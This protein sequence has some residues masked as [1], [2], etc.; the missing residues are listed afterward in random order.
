MSE[1]RSLRG[2]NI[3]WQLVHA[4]DYGVPQNRPRVLIV[5]IKKTIQQP[6]TN[7][8]DKAV[9]SGFLPD[10]V[11]GYP[12]LEEV[13]S[14]LIDKKFEYGGETTKYPFS[15]KNH[16]QEQIRTK[17][18]GTILEK[19]DHLT[20][21]EYSKHGAQIQAKFQAMIDN[22]G[23]MPKKYKTKKFAQ[24]LLP[25]K[26][27]NKGPTITIT[28]LPDDFV[29]YS[30]ARTP[31]VRECARMQT[32]PD[33]YQFAGKRTTGGI[34]RA[35]NPRENIFDREVPKYTQIGNAVPV[36][37]AYEIGLHLNQVLK[38]K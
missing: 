37:L 28:S 32:F 20:E 11:G 25:K 38:S 4:K 1:F 30:Q 15:P 6:L 9:E 18:N 23:E 34:R 27:G 22:D 33:W 31:T 12:H 10:I 2:Y 5:G 19:G 24:R 21:Q 16:W 17:P 29:H 7:N 13:F 35:G 14:D 8:E 3:R 26:W 36:K